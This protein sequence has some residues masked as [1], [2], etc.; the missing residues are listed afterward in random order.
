MSM[1]KV[2]SFIEL[3]VPVC[4]LT[5]GT[6]PCGAT[7]T[8]AS[9]CFNSRKTCIDLDELGV[10]VNYT[11]ATT[12]LRF[13]YP[14]ATDKSGIDCIPSLKSIQYR[15]QKISLAEDLGV[16]A[17]VTIT[18]SDHPDAET[19]G[20]G[21]PYWETRGYNPFEQGTFW[22]K[23]RARFP[24]MQG[25]ELRYYQGTEG[26]ELAG[27]DV[28]TFIVDKISGPSLDGKILITAKD[29]LKLADDD[30]AQCPL[31]SSGRLSASLTSTATSFTL[32]PSGV[33]N[34]EYPTSGYVTIGGREI[35]SFTRSG[36]TMTIVRARFST[37]A[38]THEESDIVQLCKNFFTSAG[39]GLDPADI[40][41]DLL[42]NYA[43]VD[44]SWITISDW[45]AKT[46]DFIGRLYYSLVAEP[47]S[48]RDLLI[49]LI[50]QC[51][52]IIFSDDVS[53]QIRLDVVREVVTAERMLTDADVMAGSFSVSDQPDKRLSQVWA[54][55]GQRNPLL[56][57][58]DTTNYSSAVA[59]IDED[60]E[61][62]YGLPSIKKIYSRWMP[63]GNR[64]A[65]I[66]LGYRLLSRFRDAPRLF[67]FDIFRR[68]FDVTLMIA[69][70]GRYDIT[71]WPLQLAT[72]ARGTAKVQVT[73]L[74][75]GD[76]VLG[77]KGEELLWHVYPEEVALPQTVIFDQD[78]IDI[79]LRA[80]Y[81]KSYPAPE[82]GSTVRFV[83]EADVVIGS[84]STSTYALSAGTWPAGV[85]VILENKGYI[86]GRGGAGGYGDR[87]W[88]GQGQKGGNAL[89]TRWP[90]TLTNAGIISTGGGGG[91]A[92]GDLP[93]D[94]SNRA[95][96]GGGGGGA[97]Y[98]YAPG[99][100]SDN[101]N[102]GQYGS[103]LYGGA[104]GDGKKLDDSDRTGVGGRGGSLN[105]TGARGGRS[106]NDDGTDYNGAYGGPPGDYAVDGN[107]Y[108]T[109]TALG[110]VRGARVN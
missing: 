41:Y 25:R 100:G 70:A 22:G 76:A 15:P 12:I 101:G 36:D 67:E 75:P 69:M 9:E 99:G 6:A 107:S 94:Y 73:Q 80:E 53:R 33:G 68:Q 106:Y 2:V 96:G 58:D 1:T 90:I 85:S 23:F 59:I 92:G 49:E 103:L 48:V 108:I 77:C 104:G 93:S 52:I 64:P 18:L 78:A 91:G 35:C 19:C 98:V 83:I 31:I 66:D 74:N 71:S 110:D 3:D 57:L 55:Y 44:P 65:A 60:A 84:L 56:K 47:T 20:A 38:E 95:G 88:S 81:D 61:T 10:P 43:A 62:A 50:E 28:R 8:T 4:S 11:E 105:Q 97:G 21:D 54:Y 7:P 30:K 32:S 13:G 17:S 51:G 82:S 102:P 34:A 46:A 72:G 14:D 16:R 63:R 87:D 40:I 109:W 42:V 5:C 86:V 24:Y 29:V 45:K 26:Q 27:M 39:E 37:D 89:Y 79:N